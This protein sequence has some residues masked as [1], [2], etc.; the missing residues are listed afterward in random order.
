MNNPTQILHANKK[1]PSRRWLSLLLWSLFIYSLF[2]SHCSCITDIPSEDNQSNESTS[3]Q[4]QSESEQPAPQAVFREDILDPGLFT[5]ERVVDGDT[6]HIKET[7][8]ALR[9][10]CVDAEEIFKSNDISQKELADKDWKEYLKVKNKRKSLVPTKYPTPV[11]EKASK[12]AKSFFDS[13]DKVRIEFDSL[14]RVIDI[15][16]RPLVYVFAQKNGT[17]TNYNV[18]LVRNGLSPY[19]MKY[20]WSIRYNDD[21]LKAEDEARK[22]KTGIWDPKEK[23]YPDYPVRISWWKDRADAIKVFKDKYGSDKSF[24]FIQN[25]TDWQRLTGKVGKKITVFGTIDRIK[26]RTKPYKAYMMYK[27]GQSII[28]YTDDDRL[29]DLMKTQY[30]NEQYVTFTGNLELTDG[31]FMMKFHDPIQIHSTLLDLKKK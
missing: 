16:H 13:V 8:D 18:E 9:L 23:H 21:F 28:L 7:N 15:Y 5:F 10:L 31:D 14:D 22:N 17:W 29:L 26:S 20:G 3:V 12:F 19:Y 25:D 27:E 6:I 11:G 24:F 2:S 4:V 1:L 30:V